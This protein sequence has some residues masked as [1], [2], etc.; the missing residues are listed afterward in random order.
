MSNG[1]GSA[2]FLFIL[3][4]CTLSVFAEK[5]ILTVAAAAN[6]ASAIPGINAVF[7][8]T[9]PGVTIHTSI[10]SS[11]ALT[12][13]ILNGAPY[14]VFLSADMS[15]PRKI[16][17]LGGAAGPPELYA[18]GCLVLVSRV[19]YV[20]SSAEELVL[21][22]TGPVVIPNPQVAPYGRAA[23]EFL[24]AAGLFTLTESRIAYTENI[25]QTVRMILATDGVGFI[26][27]SA[28]LSLVKKQKK[29]SPYFWFEI[30]S[31]LYSPIRQGCIITLQGRGNVWARK[32]LDF[33]ISGEGK[34]LL[35]LQ[36]YRIETE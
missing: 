6:L 22:S 25:S 1:R 15:F 13:Q 4:F 21:Q 34:E 16:D 27:K 20:S 8:K 28:L 3:L 9:H 18:L 26:S 24:Q 30:D 29:S 19:D 33:L 17:S 14:D 23:L 12:A 36:G 5:E 10:G 31:S 7:E 32:Y 11:G 2:L 35:R